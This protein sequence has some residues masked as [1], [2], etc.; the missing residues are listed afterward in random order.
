MDLLQQSPADSYRLELQF[1][2]DCGAIGAEN[3]S[4]VTLVRAL[5]I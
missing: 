5:I 1:L 3:V 4:I 2:R